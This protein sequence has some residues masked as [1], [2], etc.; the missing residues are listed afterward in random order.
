MTHQRASRHEQ[1]RTSRVEPFVDEE[2]LLFP[3]EVHLYLTYIIVEITT[4][5]VC[6]LRDGPD[7]AEQGRLVVESLARVGDEY[8]RDTECV[9]D[10]E[11]RRCRI[12]GRVATRLEG[13]ADAP[14]GERRSIRFLLDEQLATESLHHAPLAVVFDEGIMLLSRSLRE[15]LEPVS[16]VRRPHVLGPFLHALGHRISDAAVEPGAIV[17]DVDEFRIDLGREVAIHLLAVE[18]VFAEIR[19]RSFG[20]CRYLQRL[21]LEGLFYDLESKLV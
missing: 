10:D 4:D 2:I 6:R 11:D 18:N 19:R 3:T 9:V 21:L 15:R 5:V 8:G 20:G 12:P 13:V 7:G 1:V 16:V 14:V 17:D